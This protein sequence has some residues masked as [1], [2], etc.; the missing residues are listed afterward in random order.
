MLQCTFADEYL[1]FQVPST[2]NRVYSLI[3]PKNTVFILNALA[4]A[5]LPMQGFWNCAI[6]IATSW[7]QC[8]DAYRQVGLDKLIGR[9][10]AGFG[11]LMRTPRWPGMAPSASN[12]EA[13]HK[14]AEEV[15][16]YD[17]E[18]GNGSL[19]HHHRQ[20]RGRQQTRYDGYLQPED[21]KSSGNGSSGKNSITPRITVM[22][23]PSSLSAG[24]QR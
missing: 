16:C 24:T 11:R 12:S 21:D 4:A 13:E 15:D 14:G 5:V 18:S 2:F 17:V 6:Y 22:R 9:V 1:P 7:P 20:P 3:F 23:N 19:R 10:G 8:K